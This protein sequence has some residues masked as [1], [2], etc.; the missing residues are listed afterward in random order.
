MKL[1][2]EDIKHMELAGTHKGCEVHHI[3]TKGGHNLIVK[4]SAGGAFSVL[5]TGPHRAMA[6]HQAENMEKDIQWN[7]SLFKSEEPLNKAPKD[8]GGGH[9]VYSPQEAKAMQQKE[10]RDTFGNPIYESN[11]QNH[12]DLAAFHSK[13]A[14]KHHANQVQPG[15]SNAKMDRDMNLMHHTDI[16]LKHFQMAG[17]N[18]KQALVEH[19]KQ[20]NYHQ[21]LPEGAAAPLQHYPLELAWNRANPGKKAPKGLN[22]DFKA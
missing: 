21:E 4:K 18:P 5:G 6:R 13:L 8:L 2:P 22:Y 10:N 20:M 11:P 14:G 16:A 7:E 17:L 3:V 12:Y 15:D 19:Q 9:I 1:T